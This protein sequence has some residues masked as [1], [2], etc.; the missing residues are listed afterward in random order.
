VRQAAFEVVSI[1]LTQHCDF[2]ANSHFQATAENDP[3]LLTLVREFMATGSGARLIALF[4]Q[5]NGFVRQCGTHLPIRH[6]AFRD[7]NQL[8][9]AKKES[10][11]RLLIVGKE[12]TETYG[13]TVKD[14]LQHAHRRIYLA[15]FNLRDRG[16]GHAGLARE[17]PL[18]DSLLLTD[19]SQTTANVLVHTRLLH[20]VFILLNILNSDLKQ[21]NSLSIYI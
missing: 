14:F 21:I 5:L 20:K 18:R 2:I 12:G 4:K 17:L 7:L 15:R 13:N 3:A 9:R 6:A 8:T 19:P 10:P 16:V 1:A 11:L